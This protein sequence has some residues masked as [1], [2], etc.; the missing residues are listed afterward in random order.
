MTFQPWRKIRNKRYSPMTVQYEGVGENLDAI[1][2]NLQR[3]IKKIQE[4]CF[5]WGFNL[6][7]ENSVAIIFTRKSNKTTKLQLQIEN[8]PLPWQSEVTFLGM[9]FGE[10]L[11]W[12]LEGSYWLFNKEMPKSYQSY[13]SYKRN[14]VGSRQ[15]KFDSYISS[16]D[17]IKNRLWMPMTLLQILSKQN[18]INSS[19]K[20][21]E[22]F[23]VQW[24]VHHFN[25]VDFSCILLLCWC[26]Y[27]IIKIECYMC[28][29]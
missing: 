11:N 6:S 26:Y 12:N 27:A 16:T 7:K 14:L 25:S 28:K 21:F 5:R 29:L 13:E 8:L 20:L 15:N 24:S 10:K 4:W 17:S 1:I 9:I 19:F 23:A 18:S 22:L 2:T 3:N